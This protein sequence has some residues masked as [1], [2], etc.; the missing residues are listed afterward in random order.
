MHDALII[1]GTLMG[2][3]LLWW[4]AQVITYRAIDRRDRQIAEVSR[5]IEELGKDSS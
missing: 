1:A 4:G 3:G 5:E 2:F